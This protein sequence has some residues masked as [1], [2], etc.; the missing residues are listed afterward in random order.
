MAVECPLCEGSGT[1]PLEAQYG[2]PLVDRPCPVC[3]GSGE[4][5]EVHGGAKGA[6]I[7]ALVLLGLV[8]DIITEQAS[9][10]EDLTAAL[11]AI[12]NKVKD[13]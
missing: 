8:R 7:I 1:S 4:I 9:Q 12:W 11:E 2:D 3:Y 5:E 6:E 13:L 10:R